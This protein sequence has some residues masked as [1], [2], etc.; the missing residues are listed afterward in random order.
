MKRTPLAR[1]TPLRTRSRKSTPARTSARD[2]DCTF[3]FPGC[4]N[5]RDTVVLC[6]LREFGGG[7]ASMKPLDTEAAYGCWHCHELADGR[8][9]LIP[10]VRNQIDWWEYIARALV[11]THR[12]MRAD[13]LLTI[14]GDS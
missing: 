3:Q 12:V 10:E 4:T 9:H 1:K 7:G 2:K 8:K 14:K 11:R 5:Q 6:H 13:G